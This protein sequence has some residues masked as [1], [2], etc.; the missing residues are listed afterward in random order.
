MCVGIAH[1]SRFPVPSESFLAVFL[2]PQPEEIAVA[3]HPC[4]LHVSVSG[5]SLIELHPL[6]HILLYALTVHIASCKV[7]HCIQVMPFGS[8][9]KPLRRLRIVLLHT[10]SPQE[11]HP[12]VI[13][14]RRISLLCP[15]KP[16][17]HL[18]HHQH[19]IRL[20]YGTNH[21]QQTTQQYA[22]YSLHFTNTLS[23]STMMQSY[24]FFLT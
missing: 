6:L 8:L 24:E 9:R 16:R 12:Q 13:L 14:S 10:L 5:S 3:Q 18:F 17:L 21:S 7:V 2:Y 1:L 15:R 20:S 22:T 4:C 11:T 23:H 19:L